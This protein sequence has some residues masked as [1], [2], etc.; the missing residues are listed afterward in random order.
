MLCLE[1]QFLL[2]AVKMEKLY[3]S[4]VQ[5]AAD[6][7]RL[8]PNETAVL[9]YLRR[10]APQHDTATDIAQMQGISKALVAR[11][12]DSL[13]RRGFI[14]GARDLS[15]RRIVHLQLCGDG[16]KVAQQLYEC[17]CRIAVQLR[18]GISEQELQLMQQVMEKMQ[19]NLDMLLQ[20]MEGQVKKHV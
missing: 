5:E 4:C 16:I 20:E 2:D 8:T 11:S 13:Y 14:Q 12:V 15:D 7:C 3:R 18:C 6:G 17:G 9:L 1:E 10:H 19:H